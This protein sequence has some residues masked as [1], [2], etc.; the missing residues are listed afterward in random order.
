MI[1]TDTD[2]TTKAVIYARISSVAQL[3]K[4]HGLE[5]QATRCREYARMKNYAV[6]E[7]FHDEAVSGGV[8]DRPGITAMLEYLKQHKS[9]SP[10]VVVIDDISRIA[11]DIKTHLELRSAIAEVGAKLESPSIE[12][13]EDSDSIL[14]ENLLASVSQHQRQKNA[15]QTKNRMRARIMN[16]YWPHPAPIGFKFEKTNGR[17]K[18]LVRDEPLASIIQEALEGFAS[19]RFQMQAEVKRFLENQPAFPK[20]RYGK[21]TDEAANRILTRL[22]YAGMIESPDWGV[23]IREGQHE[24]LVSYETFLKAQDR[25]QDGA[26]VPA[27]ANINEDFPLRG[28]VCCADCNNPM[29]ASWSKS[30]TGKRHAYYMCFKKGCESYRKSIRRDKIEGEFATLLTSMQP[31]RELVT[32]AQGMFRDIWTMLTAQGVATKKALIAKVKATEKAIEQLLDRIVEADNPSLIAAYEKRIAKLEQQRLLT[33]E[34]LNQSGRNKGRFENSFELAMQLL[35]NPQKLW[36]S[37]RL[38]LQHTVLKLAFSERPAY[39]RNEGFRTPQM[40]LPFKAL[41]EMSMSKNEMA[42]TKGF[43]PSI[44]FWGILP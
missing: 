35:G 38:E 17:G 4:G 25:L 31:A 26:K 19:G 40:A 42:E 23:S 8:I 15:E 5:S 27:R 20:N 22:L 10:H 1:D 7:I 33:Q 6:A 37:G 18:V 36:A 29:T 3:Q 14:V 32:F 13:G 24:G 11:R 43:E 41:Q 39:C 2:I 44:P 34:K 12:F 9:A 21:V 28:F 16:G 30:K